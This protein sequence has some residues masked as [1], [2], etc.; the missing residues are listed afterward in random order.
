MIALYQNPAEWLAKLHLTG[1]QY[2]VMLFLF[3][4]LDFDNYLCISRQEIADNL[5]M[6]PVNVSRAMKKLKEL[7]MFFY[8]IFTNT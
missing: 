3:S 4:H 2:S 6:Q 7:E 1:E 8:E 5:R